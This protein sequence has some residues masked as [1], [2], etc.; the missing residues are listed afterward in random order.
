MFRMDGR[1]TGSYPE[2]GCEETNGDLLEADFWT[3][4]VFRLPVARNRRLACVS[5]RWKKI[6][7]SNHPCAPT[8]TSAGK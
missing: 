8:S 2:T 3:G 1:Q 4:I 7:K 6:R 5:A